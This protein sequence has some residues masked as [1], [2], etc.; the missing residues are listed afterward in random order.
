MSRDL[1]VLYGGPA[2][3]RV[4]EVLE[5]SECGQTPHRLIPG[6]SG[7]SAPYRGTTTRV[8]LAGGKIDGAPLGWLFHGT[9]AE[10]YDMLTRPYGTPRPLEPVGQLTIPFV[11]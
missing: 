4:L 6:W 7:P 10:A 3:R 8:R 11:M 2:P 5:Y 9:R 1:W